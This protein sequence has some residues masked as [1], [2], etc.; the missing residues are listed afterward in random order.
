MATK[1]TKKPFYKD[2]D[3]MFVEID[4]KGRTRKQN[5]KTESTKNESEQNKS[6]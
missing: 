4:K 3:E 6:P 2:V 1:T 5:K